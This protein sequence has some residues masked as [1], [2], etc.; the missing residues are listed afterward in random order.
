VS[1]CICLQ[2]HA[3]DAEKAARLARYIADLE[4][5]F[6][7]DLELCFVAR[8]DC[9]Q[10]SAV[11]DYVR[12]KMPVSQF[13]TR[14]KWSGWPEGPNGMAYDLLEE[15]HR[16]FDDGRWANHEA[17]LFLEPDCVPLHR[18]WTYAL[19]GEWKRVRS[20]G[21][22]VMG[23][24]RE[25]GGAHG[26]IN[27]NM[28]IDPSLNMTE[29]TA[30]APAGLAWDCAL[31]PYWHKRWHKTDLILNLFNETNIPFFRFFGLPLAFV[32]G[33]KDDSAWD[34]VKTLHLP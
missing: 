18:D 9:P 33:V 14:R 3:A 11:I 17:I 21:A 29:V 22:V 23:A 1:L 7:F 8:F 34:Y 31:A 32:H 25:S 24:W 27:G 5:G 4:H 19:L 20:G 6:R 13:T 12:K 2:F 30:S 10:D 26:H 15:M 16:R 28:L